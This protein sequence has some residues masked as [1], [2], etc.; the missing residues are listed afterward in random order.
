MSSSLQTVMSLSDCSSIISSEAVEDSPFLPLLTTVFTS[1]LEVFILCLAGYILA[2]QGILDKKTQKQL[3]RLNVSLF[4]PSLL[5]SKVAFF[6]SPE[7]LKE[8][9]IIPIFFVIVT[10]VSMTVAF[11]LGW[12]FRVKRSQ[13]NFAMAAA[14]FMN[15][16]SL[17]I[18]LM[19]SLVITVPG[20]KWGQEDNTDSMVGRALT[21]LVLYSTLGMVLRWSYGVRLLAQSD[22]ESE[23][24]GEEGEGDEETR[25]LLG[26]HAHDRFATE[27][28]LRP[29]SRDEDD[30]D[31]PHIS[32]EAPVHTHKLLRPGHERR[33]S[34][35][36]NSFPNSPNQSR[37]KLPDIDSAPNSASGSTLVRSPESSDSDS[38]DFEAEPLPLH[39]DPTVAT[40]PTHVRRPSRPI[41][42]PSA[43]GGSSSWRRNKRRIRLAWAA[44]NEFMTV[45]LWAALASLIV[46]CVQPLQHALDEHMQPIK[47]AVTSAGGCAIPLTLIVLGGYFYPA[48]P[49]PS[50]TANGATLNGN[51]NGHA[52]VGE[53][54][55]T[56]KSTTSLLESVREMFGKQARRDGEVPARAK[57][58]PGETK[59][60]VI[61]VLARMILT[62]MLLL[63]LMA[64]CAKYDFHAVF[65]DPVFVVANVLLVSS[66]PALTLAQITQAA[67][68][69]AF[70]RLISRTIFWAYCVVTP[71]ATIG[72]V[73]IGLMLSKL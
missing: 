69:D 42:Q 4:T 32:V 45:P 12:I 7:K 72:Y 15:S 44:L 64:L 68:G 23:A 5:F 13:R 63:P 33:R 36:Y 62:P 37:M 54:I 73:V 41:R 29:T 47:G 48:P 18:A 50:A 9:W 8:L 60:V 53:R 52:G 67:S 43:L 39:A 71:P 28:T 1:I 27:D 3:N 70:E 46:A 2:W 25:P 56:S 49:E 30:D 59:T 22:P 61:A 16:N 31:T 21:Y 19:Q 24:A 11:L 38:D 35:F 55:Q 57:T 40:L 17:P 58:R 66:P 34:R 6:L 20:L 26:G 65:D 14:M 10:S 51:G